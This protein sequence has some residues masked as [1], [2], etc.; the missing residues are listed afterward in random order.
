MVNL[1]KSEIKNGQFKFKIEKMIYTK[2]YIKIVSS[3]FK[4]ID[5]FILNQI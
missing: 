1:R 5:L 4:T 3:E 2:I